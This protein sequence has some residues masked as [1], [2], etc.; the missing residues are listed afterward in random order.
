MQDLTPT[1]GA[2]RVGLSL[3]T[4]VPGAVG[5][6][7]TYAREL[8]RALA[9][10]GTLEYRAFVPASAADAGEGLPTTVVAEYDSARAG[11][12]SAALARTLARPGPA[13]RRYEGLDVV[14]YPLTVPV[15]SLD[16]PKVVTL[17]DLQHLDL[18]ANFARWRRAFRAVAYDRAA[19][20]ADAVIAP[21]AI[22]RQGAIE[23]LGI[24]P[25]RAHVIP[26]GLDHA[27]F[28]PG[29]EARGEFLLYPAHGWPHKN[30]PR[31]FAALAELRRRHPGLELVLTAYEGPVPEGVR[32]L[33]RVPRERLAQLY[34]TAAALVFPSLY[35]GFG[36]PPL[37]AMACGCPVACSNTTSLPE[38][39]GDAARL[40]DPTSP[41]EIVSAVEEVLADP[42][43]WRR[44]GLERAAGFTWEQSARAHEAVYRAV[45]GG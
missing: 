4:L 30:H 21:S 26:H 37:E 19:R 11:G 24:A 35:E 13:R 12:R 10:V 9:R 43:P 27:L 18:E 1:I 15:P 45:A 17:H 41:E 3:L 5:G 2:M 16:L 40:F 44:R 38:V 32:S 6:S 7:E 42:E 29:D 36:Q 20:K 33:G 14:H 8:A 31:L 23:R 22:V 39:V 25:G 28:R 34:R